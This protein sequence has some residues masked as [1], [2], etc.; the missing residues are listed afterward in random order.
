MD[1]KNPYKS[2]E[3]LLSSSSKSEFWLSIIPINYYF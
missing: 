2:I 3:D 1:G